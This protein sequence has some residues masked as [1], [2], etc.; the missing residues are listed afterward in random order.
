VD[1]ERHDFLSEVEDGLTMLADRASLTRVLVNLLDNA[2][3]HTPVGG[4][5]RCTAWSEGEW[6]VVQVRDEGAGIPAEHLPHVFSRFHRS[7]DARDRD[8]GGTG[9]GL[10]IVK[11]ILDAHGGTIEIDSQLA[12]GTS[13]RFRVKRR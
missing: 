7:D 12:V 10:A 3:K 5:I 13:V 2:A 9:L 6:G 8:S 11:A 4:V 1:L